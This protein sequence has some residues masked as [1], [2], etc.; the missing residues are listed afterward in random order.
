MTKIAYS[1][2]KKEFFIIFNPNNIAFYDMI[3][4]GLVIEVSDETAEQTLRILNELV[5]DMKS[6]Y[7]LAY[8]STAVPRVIESRMHYLLTGE[9][10]DAPET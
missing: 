6:G 2:R 9:F 8:K 1:R 4:N 3:P 5:D 10:I 7:H